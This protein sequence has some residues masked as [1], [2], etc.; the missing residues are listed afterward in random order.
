MYVCYS[1]SR[2]QLFAT[3]WIVA[4]QAPLPMGF[5]REEYCSGLSFHPPGDLPDPGIKLTSSALA[6]GFFTSEPPGKPMLKL[7]KKIKSSFTKSNTLCK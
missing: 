5:S 1:L 2:V 4:L 7:V 3:P 6:G